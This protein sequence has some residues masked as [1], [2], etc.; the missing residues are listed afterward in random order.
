M[1][2][3]TWVFQQKPDYNWVSDSNNYFGNHGGEPMDTTTVDLTNEYV[4]L[5]R[6][7]ARIAVANEEIDEQ[8]RVVIASS[9]GSV[10]SLNDDQ[11]K[12]LLNDVATKPDIKDLVSG[13]IHPAAR[14]YM[15][16]DLA[17]LALMKTDWHPL[18]TQALKDAVMAIEISETN[19]T[20]F[21][22]VFE[23]LQSIGQTIQ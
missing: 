20:N 19:R 6:V 14:K 13:V 7:L 10:S 9:I 3:W 8:E 17:A 21:L 1:R 16:V 2:T 4:Q 11:M 15:L 23:L 18:E 12:V 5:R 22:K